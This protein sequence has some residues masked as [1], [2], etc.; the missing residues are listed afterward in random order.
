MVPDAEL[1]NPGTKDRI[2]IIIWN[3]KIIGKHNNVRNVQGKANQMI[4]SVQSFKNMF[5]QLFQKGIPSF[6]DDKEKL[7]PQ[8]E[9]Q[10]MSIEVHMDY[11]KFEYLYQGLKGQIVVDKI[12]YDFEIHS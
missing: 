2:D 5:S 7:I 1:W 4:Q 10:N 6:W 12:T 3:G 11:Y 8:E 9:Y